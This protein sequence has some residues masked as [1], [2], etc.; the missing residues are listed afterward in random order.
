MTSR[1]TDAGHLFAVP[2][3]AADGTLLPQV[4]AVCECGQQTRWFS[5]GE[6]VRTAAGEKADNATQRPAAPAPP[7]KRD[8]VLRADGGRFASK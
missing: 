2:L 3:H 1:C 6:P 7:S 4:Q 8:R 5:N